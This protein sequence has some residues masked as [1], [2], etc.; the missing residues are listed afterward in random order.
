VR[1][2]LLRGSQLRASRKQPFLL[3]N[4]QVGVDAF[5]EKAGGDLG[6]LFG[7]D[8]VEASAEDKVRSYDPSFPL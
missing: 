3:F 5:Q 6:K 1:S 2:A 4:T 8:F 7:F